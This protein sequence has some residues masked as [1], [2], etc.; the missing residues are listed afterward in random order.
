MKNVSDETI[1]LIASALWPWDS[2]TPTW[3]RVQAQAL[4][5]DEAA[6]GAIVELAEPVKEQA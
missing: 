4:L 3:C 2:P 6:V 5:A 1:E